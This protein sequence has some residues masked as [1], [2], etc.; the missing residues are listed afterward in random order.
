MTALRKKIHTAQAVALGALL[1]LGTG[2]AQQPYDRGVDQETA[3]RVAG[4]LV[5]AAAGSQIGEGSGQTV[6]TVVGALIGSVVGERIGARME[7]RDLERTARAL[8]HNERLESDR[9]VNPNTGNE[10]RVTPTDTYSR[11]GQPCRQFEFRVETELG[12]DLEERTACRQADG[13]WRI[14]D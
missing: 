1:A 14:L 9:W 4:G 12:E 5:G 10:F 3:G 7:E 8:E 6:A 13:T 2:C 11:E